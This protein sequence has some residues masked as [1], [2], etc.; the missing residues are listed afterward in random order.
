MA[1]AVC[2]ATDFLVG[3]WEDKA[4]GTFV[5]RPTS[6]PCQRSALPCFKEQKQPIG[7][8]MVGD[9]VDLKM[10]EAL[11][12]QAK[13]QFKADIGGPQHYDT[14]HVCELPNLYIMH[15]FVP[16]V[17]SFSKQVLVPRCMT[18]SLLPVR[19]GAAQWLVH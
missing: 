11:C 13:G 6:A 1:G 17:R 16:G 4:P 8:L 14:F 15:V 7:I 18:E 2:P 12:T 5:W 3:C 19:A 9:S 10:L